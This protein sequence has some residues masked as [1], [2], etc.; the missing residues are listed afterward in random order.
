MI[1][2]SPTPERSGF[3]RYRRHLHYLKSAKW[4]LVGGLLFGLLY[5]ASTGLGVPL[6]I[7]YL[8][9]IFFDEKDKIDPTAVE[10]ARYILG[11]NYVDRLLMV[12]CV[13]FPLVFALRGLAAFANR[14]LINKVGFIVLEN[15]RADAYSKLLSLPLAFYGQNKAGDL[16]LRLMSDTDKLKTVM[17]K[18]SEIATQPLTLLFGIGALV[19][20]CVHER[21]ILFA[22]IAVLSVPLCVLPIRLAARNLVK[23][24]RQLAAK[25]GQLASAS[26]EVIQAPL[27]VQAYNLQDHQRTRFNERIR[28]IFRLSLKTVKYQA[29]AT[30]L[31][32][33]VSICGFVAAIYFG[34]RSGMT[35]NSFTALAAALF[36]C[37][38]PA[39]KLSATHAILKNGEASLERLEYILDA[40]DTVPDP[41]R[42]APM[43]AGP[44]AIGLDGVSFHYA[45]REGQ[46]G[47]PRAALDGVTLRVNPGE[48]VALV[49]KTG[50]GKSTFIALLP[51]FYDPSA[52]RITL[53]GVDLRELDKHALR[54]RIAIVAQTPVL[55]NATLAE[56]I[57]F[58]RPAASDAEIELAA[59]RAC[60]HDFILSL[61]DGYATL[62]GER[63]GSLSG[64]QRQR[65]AIARAFLKD[66]PI[67]ILDE[68]TSAL[69]SESEAM[70][71]KALGELIQGRTTFMIAHRFSSIRHA[72]RI[73]VFDHG[74]IVADGPHEALYVSSPVYRELYNHQMLGAG[75]NAV[76]A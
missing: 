49:G 14:Y 63:G 71:Q 53:A 54:D 31:I 66:A 73:L 37:Y 32:E 7:R 64:G 17:I 15:L 5:S 13:G 76:P 45:P 16:N 41:V 4:P 20:L 21:S 52:G 3:R 65:I 46:T 12:A 50:A 58:G 40:R 36:F 8:L 61:P 55:F 74:R 44:L 72:T 67:L 34:T 26:I 38:E 57:R 39:K 75:G 68:A 22:L 9:P 60:I 56:N 70:I 11:E 30:P 1:S 48:T 59:R 23:R 27:E 25:S 33:F 42:P 10:I 62:V 69:D 2:D 47:S 24:S 6:A 28:D 19:V 29:I 43:P 51:R 18:I 35:Y